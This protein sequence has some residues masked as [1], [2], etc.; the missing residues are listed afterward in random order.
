[1]NGDVVTTFTDVIGTVTDDNLAFFTLA[2]APANGG[3]FREIARRTTPV[4]NGVLGRFDPTLLENGGYV[5]RVQAFDLGGHVTTVFREVGVSG[6]LKL[7]N[8]R[9]FRDEVRALGF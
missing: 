1:M 3:S 5:L 7:G 2:V 8:F 4:V 6:N 9:L